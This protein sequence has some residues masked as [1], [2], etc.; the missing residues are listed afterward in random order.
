MAHGEAHHRAFPG[1]P[2]IC[3]A[4]WRRVVGASAKKRCYAE[5]YNDLNGEVVNLFR[6][7]RETASAALII[8]QLRLTPFAR[9]EFEQ[10][11]QPATDPVESARR[12]IV[13][14]FQGFGSAG[15]NGATTGFRA[16]SDRS[17]TTPAHDWR[18][19]PD[20]LAAV[21]ERLQGVVIERKDALLLMATHDTPDTLF[22]VDPPYMPET[23]SPKVGP[24]GLYHS[25]V[26]D[27]SRDDHVRLLDVLHGLRGM[28]VLSG[29]ASQLYDGALAGWRRVTFSA[30]ADGAR[31]REEVLWINPAAAAMKSRLAAASP[32]MALRLTA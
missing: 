13:R 7:L 5:I 21:I 23:R 28:V 1:A 18:N 24:Q 11:Y 25:Y 3:G 15:V 6:V 16:S 32:Q 17:G 8:E 9:V 31:K 14:S 29:Y 19:F 20:T 22:Y 12:I 26:H 30:L 2:E 27:M 10:S 4:V